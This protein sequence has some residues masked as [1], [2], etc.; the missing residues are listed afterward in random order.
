MGRKYTGGT[1]EGI[2]RKKGSG[3]Q[4]YVYRRIGGYDQETRKSYTIKTELLGIEDPE[5]GKLRP[6]KSRKRGGEKTRAGRTQ[7]SSPLLPAEEPV[8]AD[9]AAAA[10]RPDPRPRSLGTD[11]LR[12]AG[13]ASGI[14][15]ALDAS[16]SPDES[17]RLQTVAWY[18]VV[19]GEKSLTGLRIWQ[20]DHETPCPPGLDEEACRKLWREIGLNEEG[21]RNYFRK[22]A[23]ARSGEAAHAFASAVSWPPAAG[24]EEGDFL[25]GRD[26][27][28]S[29]RYVSL[30]SARDCQ[31]VAFAH[32]PGVL[33][34][35]GDLEEA[36]RELDGA[37]L[38]TVLIV[39]DR[40]Y[41]SEGSL[42]LLC[43][44]NRGFL[45]R[46]DPD[47][48]WIAGLI[49]ANRDYLR[50]ERSR[51][52]KERNLHGTCVPVQRE[53]SA[54]GRKASGAENPGHGKKVLRRLHVHLF[55]SAAAHEAESQRLLA[56]L[57][58][59]RYD[60]Q[61]G[62]EEELDERAGRLARGFLR[63]RA[64]AG[65]PAPDCDWDAVEAA[66]KHAGFFVLV[67]NRKMSPLEAL[68]RYRRR[69]RVERYSALDETDP[70]GRGSFAWSGT[71]LRGRQFALFVAMGYRAFIEHAVNLL[72]ESLSRSAQTPATEEGALEEQVR[73]WLSEASV[74]DI[75]RRLDGARESAADGSPAAPCSEAALKRDR[76][77]LER[78]GV[79]KADAPAGCEDGAP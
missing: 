66:L 52:E 57:D 13:E 20:E 74:T 78:L 75:L 68:S 61:R 30:H 4:I 17:G 5:T 16:F 50:S 65:S 35:M 39:A 47:S 32:L 21:R 67:T 14:R 77:F 23:E 59:L 37:D 56:R 34:D 40:S 55:Y 48:P 76:F 15:A 33:P 28:P 10:G 63:P 22:R 41:F 46:A 2:C 36:V 25:S 79:L 43:G 19:S 11:L 71:A 54:S 12:W 72:R 6:T 44:R 26:A 64:K 49:A 69:A 18:L 38:R 29:L 27:R 3:G 58:Q 51:L 60:V 8:P 31:P 70:G 1:W 42:A 24:E 62:R 7:A 73:V 45:L 53:F 9:P